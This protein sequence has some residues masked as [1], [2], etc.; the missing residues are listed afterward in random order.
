MCYRRLGARR[1]RARL[2]TRH[3]CCFLLQPLHCGQF[4]GPAFGSTPLTKSQGS[5]N[6]AAQPDGYT[7]VFQNT[8][9][10]VNAPE[11]LTYV[12]LD[13]YEPASCAAYCDKT[14]GCS[15]FNIYFERDPSKTPNAKDCPN[16]P[17][18]T[19]IKCALWG[20]AITKQQ[21]TNTGQWRD[22]F[23]IVIAGSNGTP[24][25]RAL[26]VAVADL[27][28]TAYNKVTW[29][30]Q[31]V[32]NTAM[33]PVMPGSSVGSAMNVTLDGYDPA[34]SIKVSRPITTVP[35]Q[36]YVMAGNFLVSEGASDCVLYGQPNNLN[37]AFY[38]ARYP[39]NQWQPFLL[40]F[41]GGSKMSLYVTCNNAT[42]GLVAY[43]NV[44]FYP[45]SGPL[46]G[47]G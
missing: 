45:N 10:A 12:T 21:A 5:A 24:L 22:D 44:R 29:T 25:R 6:D 31:C 33:G 4:T 34:P 11:Y 36:Q 43:D 28:T 32:G 9:A 8:N 19:N 14:A 38:L 39:T 42:A 37:V 27:G 47:A 13:Q 40:P 17:S 35:N 26:G 3:R 2:V 15:A 7:T 18:T 46:R 30:A 41:F 1:F 23:Q 20:N 16:P